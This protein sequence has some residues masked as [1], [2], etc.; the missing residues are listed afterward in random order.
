MVE[1]GDLQVIKDVIIPL[2]AK[3]I[4]ARGKAASL[5]I[6]HNG[7]CEIFYF[8]IVCTYTD[9]HFLTLHNMLLINNWCWFRGHRR[10]KKCT[11]AMHSDQS[12]VLK[13]ILPNQT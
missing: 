6:N 11:N 4:E 12:V 3:S 1:W 8:I 5:V 10:V 2:G 9:V 7:K 13:Q